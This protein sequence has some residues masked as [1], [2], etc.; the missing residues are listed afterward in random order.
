MR[1]TLCLMFF[2]FFSSILVSGSTKNVS[3][4]NPVSVIYR[5]GLPWDVSRANPKSVNDGTVNSWLII[6]GQNSEHGDNRGTFLTFNLQQPESLWSIVL[7][8][9]FDLQNPNI[10]VRGYIVSVSQDSVQWNNII[11]QPMNSSARIDTVFPFVTVAK[12]LRFTITDLDTGSN[13]TAIS[14]CEIY[15]LADHSSMSVSSTANR[16]SSFELNQNYPNPFNPSTTISF[17]LPTKSFVTLKIFDVMGKE[18]SDI[19][20]EELLP[21]NYSQQWDASN[22]PSG[23]YFYRLQAG[24]FTETKRLV[25][26]K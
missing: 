19:V 20:S 2:I 17:S 22:M 21:G 12:Y 18:V 4:N 9:P 16:P 26:M 10:R 3:L 24:S 7:R 11:S 1:I 25:L 14:E 8:Q 13:Q 15:A 23:V 5:G 6:D